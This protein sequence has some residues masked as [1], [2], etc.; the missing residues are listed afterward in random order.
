M[1][2]PYHHVLSEPREISEK[3]AEFLGAA[4]DLEAMASQVD[5][6]LYRQRVSAT[7]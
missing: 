3:I 4:L 2:V 7:K 1:R 5:P 6:E